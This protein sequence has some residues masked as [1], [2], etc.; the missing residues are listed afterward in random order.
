[1]QWSY[2]VMTVVAR[3]NDLLPQTLSSLAKG[4]FDKPRLFVD[5]CTHTEAISYQEIF[6]CDIVGRFP[7]VRTC[8]NWMLSMLELYLR[9]PLAD[10]FALFQDDLVC[11][12]NLRQYL[13]TTPYP[14][15]GYLNLYTFPHN[16]E[17]SLMQKDEQGNNRVGFYQSNQRGLG[18]V[19]LVFNREAVSQIVAS[20]HM[21]LRV[22][23][24]RRGWRA[25]DGGIVTGMNKVGYKEYVH[26]PS[27]VQHTG[28]VSTIGNK[29]HPQ[30]PIFPGEDFDAMILVPTTT[31]Q[32]IPNIQ[33][34]PELTRR[35]L[36]VRRRQ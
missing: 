16:T 25:V 20:S 27:L 2:G 9:F 35:R 29:P 24:P 19:A 34:I 36:V 18:A 7:L 31:N 22:Q 26:N 8:G 23:D 32:H 1:M 14:D 3:K 5:G 15:K 13:E 4:G 17:P 10:R 11:C 33:Q 21:S 12:K 6:N 30:S 28:H